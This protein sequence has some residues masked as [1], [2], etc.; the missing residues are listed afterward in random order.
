MVGLYLHVPFCVRKCGYCDFY[1]LPQPEGRAAPDAA[2][3]L[4]ALEREMDALPA[5]FAP[6]TI[7][8]GGG[9]PTELAA[10]DLARLLASVAR[11][12]DLAGVLEW[13]CESNPG[14]LTSE[15]ARLLRDAGVNRVSLGVQ[16]FDERN[17]AFLGRIHSADEAAA[18]VRTLREAGFANVNLDLIFGIPGSPREALARDI[19]RLADLGPEHASCYCLIFEEGTPLFGK[20][21]LGLVREVDEEE[22]LAQYELAREAFARAGFRQYEISNWARPGREC[23][24]NLLYWGGGEYVGLGPSAHSH[25]G[26][27]RW[28]NVRS[29]ALYCDALLEGRSPRE[30]EERLEPEAKA[31]EAL[32][33]GLRRTAGVE[34]A[35]F[36]E[37]SGFEIEALSGPAIARLA[38]LGLLEASAERVRL[39]ERGL[40]VSDAVF[41]ELV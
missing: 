22:E 30:F 2:R 25:W 39:T 16:S 18:G 37:E 40:F 33:M 7:F 15:K 28:G 1:S 27:A 34:R 35:R 31:R 8:F 38:A 4:A 23:R 29:L 12:V 26:G 20:R 3:Y 11:R 41:A 19:A 21:A 6:E 9:T 10:E 13:T 17:L 5:G 14:T 36:R 32:V 24:H